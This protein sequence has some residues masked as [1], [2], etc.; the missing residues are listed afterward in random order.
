MEI[1]IPSRAL[2]AILADNLRLHEGRYIRATIQK[3]PECLAIHCKVITK[4]LLEDGLNRRMRWVSSGSDPMEEVR[5]Y[6]AINIFEGSRDFQAAFNELWSV[7]ASKVL[8]LVDDILN[9]FVGER[10]W[11]ICGFKPIAVI[12]KRYSKDV[13]AT[14]TED[15]PELVRF[16]DRLIERIHRK[17]EPMFDRSGKPIILHKRGDLIINEATG[18]PVQDEARSMD[19]DMILHIGQ[20]YRIHEWTRL[21][22]EKQI[23]YND[24]ELSDVELGSEES[25][26]AFEEALWNDHRRNGVLH[27]QTMLRRYLADHPDSKLARNATVPGAG[28]PTLTHMRQY[29]VDDSTSEHPTG[30]IVEDI[31]PTLGSLTHMPVLVREIE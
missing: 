6:A 3:E 31:S 17:G 19:M 21:V 22:R 25:K 20:D 7:V 5:A 1:V 26:T 10:T 23:S 13:Q 29:N 14:F 12:Y 30:F 8:P 15:T 4:I 27:T 9:E 24:I 2:A 28:V 18:T 16:G 11:K